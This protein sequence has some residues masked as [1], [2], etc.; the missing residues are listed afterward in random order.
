M[1]VEYTF[2]ALSPRAPLRFASR[3]TFDLAASQRRYSDA[4]RFSSV[5]LWLKAEGEPVAKVVPHTPP[6]ADH[7]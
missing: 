4:R 5:F 1:K 2:L 3:L 7:V 6:D